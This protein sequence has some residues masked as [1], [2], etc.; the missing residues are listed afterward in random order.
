MS[1]ESWHVMRLFHPLIGW[2]RPPVSVTEE[3]ALFHLLHHPHGRRLA[4]HLN[5]ISKT[6]RQPI[7]DRTTELK[8]I[9]KAAG[10]MQAIVKDIIVRGSTTI[11]EHEFS[12]A[13]MQHAKSNRKTDE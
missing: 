6:E 3:T 7:M 11:T 8:D 12:A 5:S 2:A 1:K 9:A 13:L 10:G 4:E